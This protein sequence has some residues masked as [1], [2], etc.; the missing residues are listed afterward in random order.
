MSRLIRFPSCTHA[1]TRP[2]CSLT[3]H[4]HTHRS[5]Q[6]CCR[7]VFLRS[8][9]PS[10]SCL[11]SGSWPLL[12]CL[13]LN[14]HLVLR[15]M[16]IYSLAVA[17]IAHPAGLLAWMLFSWLVVCFLRRNFFLNLSPPSWRFLVWEQGGGAPFLLGRRRHGLSSGFRVSVVGCTSDF[18][19]KPPARN[20]VRRTPAFVLFRLWPRVIASCHTRF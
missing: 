2:H 19:G 8:Y 3:P 20:I 10:S 17:F 16:R 1:S 18:C 5:P 15:A 14:S 11:Q 12:F 13:H 9:V 4:L 7:G 6:C